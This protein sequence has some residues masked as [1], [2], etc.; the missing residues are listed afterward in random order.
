MNNNLE[1]APPFFHFYYGVAY[2]YFFNPFMKM[3]FTPLNIFDPTKSK[4][5]SKTNIALFNK[6]KKRARKRTLF[7]II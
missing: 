1:N 3:N 7:N 5:S 4:T 6:H 2:N